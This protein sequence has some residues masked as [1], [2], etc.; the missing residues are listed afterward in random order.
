[1]PKINVICQKN[2][3]KWRTIWFKT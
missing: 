1:M 2:V 3:T